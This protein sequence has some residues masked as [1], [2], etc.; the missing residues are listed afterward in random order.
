MSKI[1]STA[2]SFI[3]IGGTFH[4]EMAQYFYGS[5]ADVWPNSPPGHIHD[6]AGRLPNNK[7]RLPLN[8]QQFSDAK[9]P[10]GANWRIVAN[11]G[12]DGKS[13]LDSYSMRYFNPYNWDWHI[14]PIIQVASDYWREN[15]KIRIAADNYL[16]NLKVVSD[17][18]KSQ[19][20]Q[21]FRLL[22]PIII[23]SQRNR[24]QWKDIYVANTDRYD[25]WKICSDDL[26]SYFS[27]RV[28]PNIIYCVTQFC[29]PDAVWD[30][31]AAG[32][33]GIMVVSSFS[34][35]MKYY[36]NTTD[37]TDNTIL[38]AMGHEIGHNLGM[39]HSEGPDKY[40]SIMY[41]AKPPEAILLQYEIEKLKSNSPFFNWS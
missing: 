39:P 16:H 18:Y 38:Y 41:T 12:D 35:T 20:G 23:C 32:G 24:T 13:P 11:Y 7:R 5:N 8:F 34:T 22:R 2:D 6:W 27:H 21:G 25:L 33:G 29:G 9:M 36:P 4:K 17:W 31:D 19:V 10:Y 3:Q 26:R 40:K 14:V 15:E 37:Q 28:N 1:I 30:Y